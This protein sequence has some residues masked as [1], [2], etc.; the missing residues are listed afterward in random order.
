MV[1]RRDPAAAHFSM[2]KAAFA[3]VAVGHRGAAQRS[4][5]CAT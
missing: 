2:T 4:L 3:G 1:A 5:P